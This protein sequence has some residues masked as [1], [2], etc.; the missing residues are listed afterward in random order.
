MNAEER[1]EMARRQARAFGGHFELVATFMAWMFWGFGSILVIIAVAFTAVEGR[2]IRRGYASRSWPV[3]TGVIVSSKVETGY[4]E[5]AG[6]RYDPKVTYRYTVAGTDYTS[7]TLDIALRKWENRDKKVAEAVVKRYPA[8]SEVE[9][10]YMPSDP[11]VS[12]LETG[13]S[14]GA[15]STV[16]FVSSFILWGLLGRATRGWMQQR[17]FRAGIL[18]MLPFFLRPLF[19]ERRDVAPPVGPDAGTMDR[20]GRRGE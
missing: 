12:T 8:G 2:S 19:A 5:G 14:R 18:T 1:M 15:W 16:I 13:V 11:S 10:R 17:R 6:N 9:V 7:G 4:A 3:A 20:D